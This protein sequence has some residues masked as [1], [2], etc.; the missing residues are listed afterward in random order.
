[1]MIQRPR[2]RVRIGSDTIGC[3]SM[4]VSVTGRVC[5]GSDTIGCISVFVSV[6]GPCWVASVGQYSTSHT[7]TGK[8]SIVCWL[9]ASVSILPLTP[10]LVS[11]QCST[12]MAWISGAVRRAGVCRGLLVAERWRY[13]IKELFVIVNKTWPFQIV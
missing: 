7:F 9:P 11:G 5:I 2:L 3:I 13:A 8:R 6:T 10:L 12:A 4:F 1:M